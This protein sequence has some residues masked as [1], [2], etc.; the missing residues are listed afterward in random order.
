MTQPRILIACEESGEVRRAF[1]RLGF[2]DV[3]SLDLK[4]ARDG[5]PNHL[6]QGLD[7]SVLEGWDLIVAFPAMHLP[8]LKWVALEQAPAR[9]G[10]ADRGSTGVLSR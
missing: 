5:S 1:E 4:P 7:E 10:G 9:T 6:Q 2:T 8:V 3:W